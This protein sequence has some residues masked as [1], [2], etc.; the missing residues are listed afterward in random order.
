MVQKKTSVNNPPLTF[1]GMDAPSVWRETPE[2]MV[3][4]M[5]EF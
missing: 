2:L 5:S 4:P 3:N 1:P